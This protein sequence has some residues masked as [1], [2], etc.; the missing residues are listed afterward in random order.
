VEEWQQDKRGEITLDHLLRMS[1]GLAFEENYAKPSDATKMLFLEKSAGRFALDHPLKDKPGDVFY[2]S[3]GTTNIL[4]EIIRRQFSSLDAYQR[5]PYEQLFQKI[6]M[7]SAVMERDPSGTYVGSS[8]MYATTRDWAKFGLLFLRNGNWN[9]EQILPEN[10][11]AYSSTETRP[12]GGVYGAHFW[13][14][15][16]DPGVP[17]DAFFA[18]GFEGQ[19]VSIIPSR[20]LV[21]VRLGLTHGASFNNSALIKSILRVI[22]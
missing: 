3:S 11:T 18:D 19:F 12:S 13:M 21:I 1:S 15:H 16:N 9:G 6:G 10:W 20:D 5:F 2:Y 8:F 17:R 14:D 4:Q 22:P 7:H